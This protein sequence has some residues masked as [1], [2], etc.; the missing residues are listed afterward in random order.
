MDDDGKIDVKT[1]DPKSSSMFPNHLCT[2]L[3]KDF[4]AL[5][6]SRTAGIADIKTIVEER[7]KKR[8]F[9]KHADRKCLYADS[10]GSISF[11]RMMSRFWANPSPFAMDLVDAVIRQGSFIDKMA[12]ID[13]YH[14]PAVFNTLGASVEKYHRFFSIIARYPGRC[15]VP[16]LNVDLVWHTH[17]LSPNAYWRYSVGV[18]GKYIVHDDKIEEAKLGES[19]QWTSE[20]YRKMYNESYTECSPPPR[21]IL[22][23]PCHC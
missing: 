20:K 2:Y 6:T 10:R 22:I 4:E 11:R 19:Y 5:S 17:M 1:T 7:M 12:A 21:Q 9:F 23:S 18:T 15:V 14:S 13:W 8:R 3:G 16:T